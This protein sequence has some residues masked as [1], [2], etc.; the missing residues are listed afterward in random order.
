V[1]L[2]LKELRA[3]REHQLRETLLFITSMVARR[4]YPPTCREIGEHLGL[5][6]SSS[7]H[8]VVEELRRRGLLTKEPGRHRAIRVGA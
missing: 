4:G 5:R 2:S 1:S 7:A 3:H 8:G 6:S